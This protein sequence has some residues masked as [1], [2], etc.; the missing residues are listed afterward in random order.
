MSEE[1]IKQY[2]LGIIAPRSFND[3]KLLEDLLIEKIFQIRHIYSNGVVSGGKVVEDFADKYKII[4][5]VYPITPT[6]GGVFKSNWSVIKYSDFIYIL[7]DGHSKNV[8]SV[9]EECEEQ[10]KKFKVIPYI[11]DT[12]ITKY[13][14]LLKKIEELVLKD[15][16]ILEKTTACSEI[17][18]LIKEFKE[19]N[20]ENKTLSV[21]S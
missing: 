15:S 10:K 16:L 9:I 17:A 11:P 3:L 7:D 18:K 13:Q 19:P 1:S 20:V 21:E 8:K 14:K 6:N 2:S 5:T 4:K 12:P